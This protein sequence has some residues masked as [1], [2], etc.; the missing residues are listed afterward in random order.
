METLCQPDQTEAERRD[1][2][3]D[4]NGMRTLSVAIFYSDTHSRSVIAANSHLYFDT[5]T[6][7]ARLPQVMPVMDADIKSVISCKLKSLQL[8]IWD[9]I[10]KVLS[11]MRIKGIC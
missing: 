10:Y 3:I 6:S 7:L 2:E 9:S 8:R 11:R 4:L 1:E 5:M